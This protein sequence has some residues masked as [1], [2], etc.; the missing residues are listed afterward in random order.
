MQSKHKTATQAV[1]TTQ[2]EPGNAR[3]YAGHQNRSYYLRFLT[4]TTLLCV[5]ALAWGGCSPLSRSRS[6]FPEE[7]SSGA[8]SITAKVT[9]PDGENQGQTVEATRTEATETSTSGRTSQPTATVTTVLPDTISQPSEP[10]PGWNFNQAGKALGWKADHHLA[11]FSFDQEGLQTSSTGGDPYMSGPRMQIDAAFAPHLEIRMRSTKGNDAQVFWVVRNTSGGEQPFNEAASQHFIV[12]PDGQ[13]QTYRLDLS[14]HPAWKGQIT[15]LRLDP[16]NTE[17]AEISIAW[18]RLVGLLPAQI[19]A[20]AFGPV[21][22]IQAEDQSFQLQASL[23]N[24]GDLAAEEVKIWLELPPQLT[25]E[26]KTGTETDRRETTL[27]SLPAGETARQT[28]DLRGPAGVHLVKLMG[29]TSGQEDRTLRQVNVVIEGPSN[30]TVQVQADTVGLNFSRQPFGYGIAT[31]TAGTDT[32]N[33]GA[34]SSQNQWKFIGR[35]LS[36]GRIVYLNDQGQERE[37]LLYDSHSQTSTAGDEVKFEA[38]Y[39]DEDGTTWTHTAAFEAIVGKPWIQI[40]VELQVDQPVKLLSWSG[41]D[42]LA[43]E[44]TQDQSGKEQQPE[45]GRS[46]LFPGLEFLKTGE[47]SSGTDYAWESVAARYVPHPNKITIPLMSINYLGMTTGLLW[48]PLQ[49]PLAGYDRPAALYASPNTWDQQNNHLMRLFFPGMTAGLR[50]NHDRLEEPFLLQAGQKL[51]LDSALFA[52]PERDL[53]SPLDIWLDYSGFARQEITPPW[54]MADESEE[55]DRLRQLCLTSYTQT[56]WESSQNGWH[57]TLENDPWGPGS[58]PAAALHLW[59]SASEAGTETTKAGEWRD[60]VRQSLAN[61]PAGGQPNIWRYQPALAM[62]MAQPLPEILRLLSFPREAAARQRQ[63][64][65]WA[66]PGS[67]TTGS[68]VEFGKSGDTSNGYIATQAYPVLYYARLTGEP[69]LVEAGLR[70]LDYLEAQPLRPEGAQTWELSLHVPDL[71]ASAWVMQSFV[72]GYRLTGETRYLQLAQRWALAGLPFIYLWS[73]GNDGQ[74]GPPIMRYTT[75]PVFGATNFTYPWFGR[76]VMWNGLDYA[77]GLQ[78]L[79]QELSAAGVKALLNWRD[80]AAG[81]TAATAQMMPAEGPFTGMYP[82]AWDVTTGAE[83]YSWWLMPTYVMHNLLLLEGKDSAETHTVILP[84]ANPEGQA[85]HINAPGAILS[86]GATGTDNTGNRISAQVQVASG[87]T[88][89]VWFSGVHYPAQVRVNDQE[90]IPGPW[91]E[92]VPNWAFE[93][94]MLL[95]KATAGTGVNGGIVTIEFG[96]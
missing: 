72:E 44:G 74:N 73:P 66:Y 67:S 94:G 69:R 25:P 23:K 65:S 48:D 10:L 29:R 53:L 2:P 5:L 51:R 63:D 37:V 49:A 96:E 22:G 38:I 90:V 7:P 82:D 93:Q 83:A 91:D 39:Q 47:N 61:A 4:F 92:A 32:W 50:E 68:T 71:L 54:P 3:K 95:V 31:V 57:Y 40:S 41:P 62:H 36:L 60:M 80:L 20:L 35:L 64:G 45:P 34:G 89:T 15:R 12:Q 26:I 17:G 8:P 19:E 13:W 86:A 21:A 27:A 56:T 58:N 1:R 28:W 52:A 87:E 88:V 76:P 11:R 84:S 33:N 43:G 55:I 9:A 6:S 18:I 75:I 30:E 42:Y 70:A 24:T 78:A 85:V 16:S 77:L 79:D 81:I 46:G 59:I 14:S